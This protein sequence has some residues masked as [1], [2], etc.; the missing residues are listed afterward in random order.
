MS[1]ERYVTPPPGTP[2][3]TDFIEDIAA[4]RFVQV[5]IYKI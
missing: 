3:T 5:L 2:E 4:V 1:R